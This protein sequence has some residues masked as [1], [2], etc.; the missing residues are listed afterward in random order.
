VSPRVNS[1][2]P[3]TRGSTPTWALIGR[4]VSSA[5]PSMRTLVCSTESRRV[6][7]SSS[8]N[9]LDI[10]ARSQPLA[11]ASSASCA[12]TSFFSVD[13]ASRRC[14]LSRI[15]KAWPR[16]SPIAPLSASTMAWS[17]A[18]AVHSH[19]GLP[20]VDGIGHQRHLLV[21]ENHRSEHHVLGQLLGFGLHH[22]HRRGGTGDDQ[23]EPG[24]L[25]FADGRVEQVL[26]VLVTDLGGADRALERS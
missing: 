13:S 17:A 21:A 9:S 23:L 20:R 25:Q 1:D 12:S 11:S 15:A 8:P 6:W 7:Y 22:Q 10:A 5:R 18:G 26:A 14:S 2:E 19:F 3:C 24:I 4:T 16:R